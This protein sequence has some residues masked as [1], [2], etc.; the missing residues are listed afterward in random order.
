MGQSYFLSL[1]EIIKMMIR[2][3]HNSN[4]IPENLKI[5]GNIINNHIS[6]LKD[7]EHK[8]HKKIVE[9]CHIGKFLMNLDKNASIEKVCEVPDFLI[10]YNGEIIGVEHQIIIDMDNKSY[11]G[12]FQNIFRHSEL[13]LINDNS[14]PNI[15]A[16]CW[17]HHNIQYKLNQKEQ[18]IRIVT[19]TIKEY[20]ISGNL[21]NNPIIQE[22]RTMPHTQI[23]ICPNFGGWIQKYLTNEKLEK[24]IIEKEKRLNEYKKLAN[25]IWLLI[26]I[27]GVDASSYQIDHSESYQ[28]NSNFDGIFI[29]EDFYNNLYQLK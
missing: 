27:G 11:E 26:V 21:K 3:I 16:N 19:E 18:Y 8:N 14:F 2:K 24:S 23:S 1:L 9:I 15:L 17:L 28:I 6:E 20:V 29:M 4:S 5:L 7:D 10:N 13:E 22:I 25:K 12:F